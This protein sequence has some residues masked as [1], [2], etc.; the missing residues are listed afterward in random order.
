MSQDRNMSKNTSTAVKGPSN[1]PQGFMPPATLKRHGLK[2]N[3]AVEKHMIEAK[4]LRG[5]QHRRK[6][7]KMIE[8]IRMCRMLVNGVMEPRLARPLVLTARYFLDAQKAPTRNRDTSS[9]D[10]ESNDVEQSFAVPAQIG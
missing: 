6:I 2:K 3:E 7:K 8:A 10:K 4:E 5:H 9:V 1:T